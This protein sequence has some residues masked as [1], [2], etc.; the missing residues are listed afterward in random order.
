MKQPQHTTTI[1]YELLWWL[2]CIGGR[3]VLVVGLYCWWVC[4]S[5]ECVSV[6]CVYQWWVCITE[7]DHLTERN[8]PTHQHLNNDEYLWW[9]GELTRLSIGQCCNKFY[10]T[11]ILQKVATVVTEQVVTQ[12]CIITF[13]YKNTWRCIYSSTARISND[14]HG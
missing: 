12:C 9:R 11:M 3:C 2:V 5:D 1:H 13:L 4:T 10:G 7:T 8:S 6:V 14:F